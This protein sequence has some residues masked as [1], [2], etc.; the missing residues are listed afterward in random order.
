MCNTG[1]CLQFISRKHPYLKGNKK[2][3]HCMIAWKGFLKVSSSSIGCIF[4]CLCVCV[5]QTVRLP[6]SFS[7]CLSVRLSVITL[8]ICLFVCSSY[9]IP[10][11]L[12]LVKIKQ[13]GNVGFLRRGE[14]GVPGEKPL[15]ARTRANNK[16]NSHMT[17]SPGI[18]PGPHWWEVS[19]LTTA[20]SLLLCLFHRFICSPV[21]KIVSCLFGC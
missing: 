9:C 18:E 1:C 17:P 7:V 11:C 2:L 12:F 15:R 20:P 19:A 13:F 21:R 6:F 14:T 8:S 3:K 16:L 10:V 4:V 5:R